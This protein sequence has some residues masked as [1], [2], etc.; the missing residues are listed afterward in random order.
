M[1]VISILLIVKHVVAA[2][3]VVVILWGAL[4]AVYRFTA[5]FKK[6]NNIDMIRLEFA[7]VIILGLEFIVAAD[8]IATTTSP[9]YYSLGILASLVTI[10]TL[11]TYFMNKEVNKLSATR[12]KRV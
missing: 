9:D 10:R 7:R 6:R 1:D 12:R 4:Q 2:I 8:V 3:G 5:L 11:L